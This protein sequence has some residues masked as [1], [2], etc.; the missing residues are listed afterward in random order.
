MFIV[1][2]KVDIIWLFVFIGSF[3]IM[4]VELSN[5]DLMVIIFMVVLYFVSMLLV[6]KL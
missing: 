4:F 5:K 3:G 1:L 6:V 2:V